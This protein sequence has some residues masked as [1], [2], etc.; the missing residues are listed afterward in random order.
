MQTES[1][2]KRIAEKA[3]YNMA[4]AS[5][6]DGNLDETINWLIRSSSILKK[7]NKSHKLNCQQYISM[8]MLRKKEIERLGK[9]IRN[10]KELF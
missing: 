8:L 6:M 10:G 2:N 7:N 1:K 4:L 5:E 9:Q 3:S